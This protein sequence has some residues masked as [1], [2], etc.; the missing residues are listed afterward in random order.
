MLW[1]STYGYKYTQHDNTNH[2]HANSSA[3]KHQ[4][5]RSL[6]FGCAPNWVK[7]FIIS[8]QKTV[9]FMRISNQLFRDFAKEATQRPRRRQVTKFSRCVARKTARLVYVYILYMDLCVCVCVYCCANKI[10][11]ILIIILRW[12]VFYTRKEWRRNDKESSEKLI[13]WFFEANACTKW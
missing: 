5:Q 3:H 7:C 9:K 8:C 13:T 10:I 6:L 11:I 1:L 4:Q 12:R 2:I